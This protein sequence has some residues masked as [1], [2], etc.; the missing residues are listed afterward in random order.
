VPCLG[1]VQQACA[2]C[3]Y[4]IHAIEGHHQKNQGP[5]YLRH[6]ADLLHLDTLPRKQCYAYHSLAAVRRLLQRTAERAQKPCALDS[7]DACDIQ[8]WVEAE[9]RHMGNAH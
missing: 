8:E 6:G 1:R 2:R 9:N 7:V 4:F 3:T 5:W